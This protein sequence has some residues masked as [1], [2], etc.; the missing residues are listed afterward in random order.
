VSGAIEV[1][2]A[3]RRRAAAEG[4]AAARWLAGLD[5]R[6]AAVAADWGLAVGPTLAGSTASVVVAVTGAGGSPAVLKLAL[7][8]GDGGGPAREAL[9]LRRAGGRGCVRLL[10]AEPAR[11]ALLLARLGRQLVEV[12]LP[13]RDQI[14]AICGPLAELWAVPPGA[15]LPTGADHG[16]ALAALIAAEWDA[17]GRPGPAA[18]ATA[19]IACAERRARAH[20]PATAVLAHGDAHAWNTLEDPAAG[21]GRYALVDPDGLVADRELDLAISLREFTDELAAGDARA[22][23]RSRADLLA[24]LTGTDP[25]AIWEWGVAERVANGLLLLR[26]GHAAAGRLHLAVAR[27][28]L[29]R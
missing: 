18:V 2:E 15:G 12:G 23:G 26:H 5:A 24:A 8:D 10:R 29:D 17:R 16:R 4:G 7:P 22:L 21:P 13:V 27:R 3:V 28:W 14:A 11:G 1:P 6:V 9:V 19:A 20:D 25:E